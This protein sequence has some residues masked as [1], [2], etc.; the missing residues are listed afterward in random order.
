VKVKGRINRILLGN[1]PLSP[2]TSSHQ[3]KGII[4]QF[5][6]KVKG[7]INTNISRDTPL[8][9]DTSSHQISIK[10]LHLLRRYRAEG[11]SVSRSQGQ[12]QRSQGQGQRSHR[13][14][15]FAR[16]TFAPDTSSHQISIKN[17][18]SFRNYRVEGKYTYG[19]RRTWLE[20]HKASPQLTLAGMLNYSVMENMVSVF[21]KHNTV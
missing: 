16:H 13:H 9:P 17:L 10:N 11:I 1:T 2:D 20:K 12:G 6:V 3:W 14:D 4:M 5:W 19:G 8:S 21:A 7:R 15:S 18:Q